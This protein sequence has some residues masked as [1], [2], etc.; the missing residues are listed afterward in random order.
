MHATVFFV[1]A[2]MLAAA[3]AR[4]LIAATGNKT[5]AA[6]NLGPGFTLGASG[7]MCPDVCAAKQ[8]RSLLF[9]EFGGD[10]TTALCAVDVPGQGWV[11][12][13]QL[14]AGAA[15]CTVA[16]DGAATISTTYACGCMAKDQVQGLTPPNAARGETCDTAC[17]QG[18]DGMAGVGAKSDKA[19]D[20]RASHACVPSNELGVFNRFG[21]TSPA[22]S[23]SEL[24]CNTV[25]G[26]VVSSLTDYSCVCLF[27]QPPRIAPAPALAALVTQS[28]P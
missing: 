28:L 20:A 11:A 5:T 16:I 25:Q 17:S 18:Y 21:Y 23:G 12:G 27:S 13:Y 9:K 3:N 8:Q 6:T 26:A 24:V 7:V 2:C 1:F 15:A 19:V 14:S 4:P 22:V 10:L